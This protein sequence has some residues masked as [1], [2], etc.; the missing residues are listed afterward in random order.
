MDVYARVNILDGRAVRLPRGDVH[1]AIA[2][3]ND[4]L[5]RIN[6]WFQQ[7]ADY[8]HVVDLDAAA[9]GDNKNRY[10]ID[11]ILEEAHGPVQIAGGIRSHVEAAR[12]LEGGAWRIVMGTAAIEDQN[13]VWDLCREFPGRIA[14]SLDVRSDEEIATRG[15]TKNSGRYLEEVLIEMSSAG[16]AAFLVSEVGRDVLTEQTNVQIL[17]EALSTVSEPIVAAGGVRDLDDLKRLLALEIHGRRLAGVVVGREVTQGRFTLAE[18]KELI[19][20]GPEH[21]VDEVPAPEPV[22]RPSGPPP[23]LADAAAAYLRAAEAAESAAAHARQ[24]A[25]LLQSGEGSKG[26]EHAFAAQGHLAAAMEQIQ[27]LAKAHA[28]RTTL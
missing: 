15:W 20:A 12:L 10:L 21:T 26:A 6:N 22:A 19:A 3:H 14:I 8:V 27:N 24:A 25:S 5:G 4:P 2:L 23:L 11:R 16:A 7:G 18:A 13:M 9:F 28:R 1:D 17:A